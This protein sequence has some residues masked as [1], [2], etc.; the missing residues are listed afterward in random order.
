MEVTTSEP[1]A[2]VLVPRGGRI[3]WDF[4][5][6]NKRHGNNSVQ[7][8]CHMRMAGHDRRAC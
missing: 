8:N 7:G 1:S 6:L 2:D 4:H 3:A 5:Y